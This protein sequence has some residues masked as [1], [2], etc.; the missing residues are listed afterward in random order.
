MGEPGGRGSLTVEDYVWVAGLALLAVFIW[1]RDRNWLGS[2]SEVVPILAVLPLFVW[3]GMPWRLGVERRE[4]GWSWLGWAG[5][6][7]LLGVVAEVTLLLA[8]A[9]VAALW[10]W[11]GARVVPEARNGVARLLVLPVM[12]FPWVILDG[13][14]LGWWF[15]LSAAW[16]AE[17]VFGVVGLAVAREGTQLVVQGLPVA[18]DASC[19]GLR[20]LQAMLI[21]G[22]VLVYLE[23]R[24]ARGYWWALPGL[25]VA[26]WLANVLRV[27]TL[28]VAAL[29][30]GSEFARG[31]FHAWGGWF[32][33]VLMFGLCWLGLVWGR[34]R[35][36]RVREGR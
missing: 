6:G 20:V 29:T 33:L 26:A 10:A 21:A 1:V 2:A 16:V 32:V 7:L 27:L 22:W 36:L 11:L 5:G 12:G 8:L 9:W 4:W 24:G 30:F 23:L 18:V 17:Q 14:W 15:R 28:C 13:G 31:W 3:L 34:G 35:R 19:S 25:V